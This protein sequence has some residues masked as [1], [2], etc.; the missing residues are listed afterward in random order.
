MLPK[1]MWCRSHDCHVVTWLSSLSKAVV[2]TL[3]SKFAFFHTYFNFIYSHFTLCFLFFYVCSS[4][5]YYSSQTLENMLEDKSKIW[6]IIDQPAGIK[7]YKSTADHY[8]LSAALRNQHVLYVWILNVSYSL[9][10]R[11]SYNNMQTV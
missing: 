7:R 8:F 2:W 11:N 10:W 6:F 1:V 4:Y 9:M 3:N 5:F